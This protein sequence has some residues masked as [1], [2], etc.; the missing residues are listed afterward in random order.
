MNT[1]PGTANNNNGFATEEAEE[2]NQR[3]VRLAVFG[4]KTNTGIKGT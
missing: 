3:L 4:T 1:E 2:S